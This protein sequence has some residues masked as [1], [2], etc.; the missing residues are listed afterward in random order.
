MLLTKTLMF[1]IIQHTKEKQKMSEQLSFQPTESVPFQPPTLEQR[2]PDVVQDKLGDPMA[3]DWGAA[4]ELT[5]HLPGILER[6]PATEQD[7][8]R[9]GIL[10]R[11]GTR[12]RDIYDVYQAAPESA[13]L[14]WQTK[15]FI[16]A[17]AVL[18]MYS[19]HAYVD[20]YG[21]PDLANQATLTTGLYMLG[22]AAAYKMHK[23]G[24]PGSERNRYVSAGILSERREEG[25]QWDDNLN[26]IRRK[27]AS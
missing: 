24:F 26:N 15:R 23:Y 8:S 9:D 12:I 1:V 7:E 21:G 11:I 17:A 13:K 2:A 22:G 4:Q 16:G 20:K 6:T 19:V 25:R 3:S 10:K 14:R 5:P 18:S 27:R